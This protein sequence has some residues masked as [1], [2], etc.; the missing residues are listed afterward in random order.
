LL[1]RKNSL[2]R[3]LLALL[4]G[5]PWILFALVRIF[6]LDRFWPL[7]PIVAFI[8]QIL[9]MMIVPIVAAIAM[10]ARFMSVVLVGLALVLV[11]L[12]VP[13]ALKNDQPAARGQTITIFSANLLRG[14]ADPSVLT[15]AIN[16]VNPDIVALQEATP[17]TYAELQKSGL[18][19]KYPYYSGSPVTGTR[20]YFTVANMPLKEIPATGLFGGFWPEMRVGN[21]GLLFRNIH[22]SSPLKPQNTPNW[23]ETLAELPGPRNKMRVIAGDFNATL[24]HRDFRALLARGYRDSGD[25]TGHGFAWTWVVS[26]TGRLV[27]DHVLV[28]RGVAIEDYRVIDLPGSD[29][30]AVAVTL[31]LP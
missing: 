1:G 7:I 31:R 9:V 15:G 21:T 14:E 6:S 30:N 2:R 20:G 26:R 16:Q 24:D 19:K 28:P 23:K 12:L 11:A 25:Q 4:I 18:L 13:R 5:S 29:H 10:R 3:N 22:T 17:L 8:P 27:I